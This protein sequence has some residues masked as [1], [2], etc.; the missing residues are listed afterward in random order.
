MRLVIETA[1][2]PCSVALIADDGTVAAEAHE[3]I[4]RG[5]AERLVPLIGAVMARAGCDRCDAVLVDIGPGSFTGLRVGIAAARA[6][7]LAWRAPV[8]GCTSTALVAAG[9]FVAY[10]DVNRLHVALDA[11]RGEVY[12]QSFARK[13]LRPL[14]A[15]AA[16]TPSEA[17]IRIGTGGVVAGSGAALV[18]AHDA[19]LRLLD[20]AWPRA[21]DAALLPLPVRLLDPRPLYV[22]A[23]DAKVPQ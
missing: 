8:T 15:V 12:L 6:F 14:D 4:G 23:P 13:D 2:E 10:A 21:R 19:S 16:V 9:A 18:G 3:L 22:R 17:A 7:G 11:A 5:H 20:H 1:L